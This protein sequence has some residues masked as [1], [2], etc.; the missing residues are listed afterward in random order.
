MRRMIIAGS[1]PRAG[2]DEGTDPDVFEVASRHDVPTLEDF[3]VAVYILMNA[4]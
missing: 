1:K 4:A 2:F 3:L